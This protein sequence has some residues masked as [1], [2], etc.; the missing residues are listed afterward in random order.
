MA[1]CQVA[2]DVGFELLELFQSDPGDDLLQA[3]LLL[4]LENQ[5]GVD[6]VVAEPFRQQHAD[7]AFAGSGHA[8]QD[9]I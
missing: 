4:G 5:V 9:D 1:C 7:R 8:D 2:H 3:A 6:K